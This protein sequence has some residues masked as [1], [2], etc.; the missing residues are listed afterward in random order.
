MA[1]GITARGI[2]AMLALGIRSGHTLP[3]MCD[4][5]VKVEPGRVLFAKNSDRDA[6]EPQVL[7]WQPA[8]SH[9]P[10]ARLRC[11]W[12]DIPQS[13]ETHAVLLCRPV[14]MW[15][16]E[17][18]AN[19][20]GVI[21]GNEAVFTRQPYAKSGLTGMDLVRLGAERAATAREAVETITE[22]LETHGQGGGCGYENRAFTYHNSF[23][24]AD[25]TAAFVLETAG[26][27]WEVEEV[28][29]ARSISNGLTIPGFAEQY[30]DPLKTRIGGCRLRQPRTQAL[31]AEA[32]GVA[33]FFALLRDHG[34]GRSTPRYAWHHGALNAP[35][36]HAGGLLASAQTTASWVAELTP[37]GARHWVTATAATTTS[38]FKPVRVD[39]PLDLGPPPGE[40]ADDSLWWRHERF[41]RMVMRDPAR[42]YPLFQAERDA[43]E[44]RWL[45]NPPEPAESFAEA[46]AL[47]AK[48]T[49]AVAA[50]EMR[51][52][53]PWF[54]RRHWRIR[55]QRAGI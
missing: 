18:A 47:L 22:L 23:L 32:A 21:I 7:E 36:V 14:W 16:A 12:L 48:W 45:I 52:T 53:R 1:H 4:T 46:D 19:A 30:A 26:K 34:E 3:I 33:D 49:T 6:N 13:R 40:R 8:R 50:L 31:A 2:T 51:D 17:M 38:L 54:V 10:E 5:V 20:H 29:G 15:G 37:D 28:S 41:H 24:I 25:A 42:A 9:A 11:T 27:Q 55:N 43:V 35:S 44:A 39:T